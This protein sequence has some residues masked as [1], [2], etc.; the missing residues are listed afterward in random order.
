MFLDE[1]ERIHELLQELRNILEERIVREEGERCGF[2]YAM[3]LRME[4][5]VTRNS[6]ETRYLMSA[7]HRE[8]EEW[9]VPERTS[10]SL[11]GA[12]IGIGTAISMRIYEEE[13]ERYVREKMT[14]ERKEGF[15]WKVLG[16]L[17]RTG[18]INLERV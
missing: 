3:Q 17:K 12:S 1:E 4:I 9:I 8:K 15:A 16:F 13:V 14:A 2:S 18:L 10:D 6:M 5:N 7:H 11:I